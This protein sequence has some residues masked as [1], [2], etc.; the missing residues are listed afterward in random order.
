MVQ[1]MSVALERAMEKVTLLL[2]LLQQL[3]IG[4]DFVAT[5][6]IT[7]KTCFAISLTLLVQIFL[8]NSCKHNLFAFTK[9][10]RYF[11]LQSI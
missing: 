8:V 7:S 11:P 3:L 4:L 9:Y 6:M 10:L 5:V 1:M 2:L